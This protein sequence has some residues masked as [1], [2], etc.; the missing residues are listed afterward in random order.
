M[1][2]TH[3]LGTMPINAIKNVKYNINSSSTADKY[4]IHLGP[5]RPESSSKLCFSPYTT[6]SRY[7]YNTYSMRNNHEYLPASFL[8]TDNPYSDHDA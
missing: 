5:L 1:R 4:A 8:R 7:I 2:I 3:C 6:H